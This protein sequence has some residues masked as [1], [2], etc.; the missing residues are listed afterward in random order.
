[1]FFLESCLLPNL[2]ISNEATD[3]FESRYFAVKPFRMKKQ[4][5]LVI[6]HSFKPS[7]SEPRRQL[8]TLSDTGVCVSVGSLTA[9]HIPL[10]GGGR[11]D[12]GNWRLCMWEMQ[13]NVEVCE[14]S[15]SLF[16]EPKTVLT[17]RLLKRK[18]QVNLSVDLGRKTQILLS[19]S[20]LSESFLTS[21]QEECIEMLD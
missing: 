20:F 12:V 8:R 4:W 1:M 15:T 7:K 21:S 16:C 14:L 6:V 13:G 10:R 11:G 18:I 17:Y 19:H 2:S 3:T 9:T 5:L